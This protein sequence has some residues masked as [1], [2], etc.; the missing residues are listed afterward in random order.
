MLWAAAWPAAGARGR[1]P[2]GRRADPAPSRRVYAPLDEI[3][4]WPKGKVK[5]LPMEAGQFDR[6][7]AAAEQSRLALRHKKPP[8]LGAARYQARLADDGRLVGQARLEIAHAA[9]AAVLLPLDP[10]NLALGTAH[11]ADP[12]AAPARLG[13]TADGRLQALV[14]RTGPLELAWSLRAERRP[15]RGRRVRLRSARKPGQSL[16]A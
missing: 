16:H 13:L 12:P 6:L 15:R 5:Y 10:C 3:Q 8:R 4:D 11:W 7:V 1:L 9:Q 14:E 2:R